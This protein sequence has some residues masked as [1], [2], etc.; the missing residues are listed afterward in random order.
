MHEFV[1]ISSDVER[2]IDFLRQYA[3][4]GFE[5]VHVHNVHSD[6]QRFIDDFGQHVLPALREEQEGRK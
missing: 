3:R 6:Q 1:H 2:H 5:T 4:F